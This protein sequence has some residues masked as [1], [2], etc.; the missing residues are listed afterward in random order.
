[1][2]NTSAIWQQSAHTTYQLS[3]LSCST[4]PTQNDLIYKQKEFCREKIRKMDQKNDKTERER[5]QK[6]KRLRQRERNR[7]GKSHDSPEIP[8]TRETLDVPSL[9]VYIYIYI[10]TGEVVTD[11]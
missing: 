4:I 3:S 1:M 6:N 10:Y 8:D 7:E 2:A 11:I 5:R 9:P